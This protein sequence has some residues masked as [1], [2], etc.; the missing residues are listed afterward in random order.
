M[1]RRH[2]KMKIDEN[3]VYEERIS[4]FLIPEIHSMR[5]MDGDK[6][7]VICTEESLFSVE[8]K[9]MVSY[10]LSKDGLARIKELIGNAKYL[11]SK[12]PLEESG[13]AVL[14]GCNEQYFF[15]SG[16]KETF[17][18]KDNFSI[19]YSEISKDTKAGEILSIID[20][21]YMILKEH[22]IKV[23]DLDDDGEELN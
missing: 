3:V 6:P 9:K 13:Y 4:G 11:F 18:E 12:A 7:M 22:D 5:I 21:I 17:I 20:S 1:G 15:R 2:E 16:S 14:D 19:E 23:D 10:E 8:P